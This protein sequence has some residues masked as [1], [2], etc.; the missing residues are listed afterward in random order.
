MTDVLLELD[1][2]TQQFVFGVAA[3]VAGLALA[4]RPALAAWFARSAAET[5]DRV[6]RGP[7]TERVRGARRGD[8]GGRGR[9]RP[10]LAGR[11]T[12]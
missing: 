11:G 9:R 12:R 3:V 2:N 8:G 7:I 6:Q 5:E 4:N 10:V 1:T